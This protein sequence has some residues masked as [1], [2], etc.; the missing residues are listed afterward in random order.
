MITELCIVRA[1][2]HRNR[3]SHLHLQ[4]LFSRKQNQSGTS[5]IFSAYRGTT[6]EE[7]TGIKRVCMFSTQCIHVWTCVCR[8][9]RRI[10]GALLYHSLITHSLV[11][12]LNQKGGWRPGRPIHYPACL[13]I[14]ALCLG[15]CRWPQPTF[16]MGARI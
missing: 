13:P 3:M 16:Y 1:E 7:S 9:L 10:L 5:I 12:F 2:G 6:F 4:P 8:R 14:T 15:L 11:F